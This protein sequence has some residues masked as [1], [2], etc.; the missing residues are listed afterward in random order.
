MKATLAVS[1]KDQLA[2]SAYTLRMVDLLNA[3]ASRDARI[4]I[5]GHTCLLL[6]MA[7]EDGSGKSFNLRIIGPDNNYYSC[8]TRAA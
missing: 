8:Y 2:K 6:S 1:M 5:N 4:K 7:R 3:I